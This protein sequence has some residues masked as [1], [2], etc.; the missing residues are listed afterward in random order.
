MV[1]FKEGGPRKS[2]SQGDLVRVTRIFAYHLVPQLI[3]TASRAWRTQRGS[4]QV[5]EKAK[6]QEG[7]LE[8]KAA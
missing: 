7:A 1:S 3:G 2:E 8:Q 4:G 6:A 5:M